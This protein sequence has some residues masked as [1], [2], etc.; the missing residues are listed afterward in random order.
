[1]SSNHLSANFM[2]EETDDEWLKHLLKAP[3]LVRGRVIVTPSFLVCKSR[4]PPNA[5]NPIQTHGLE[6]PGGL[7]HRV[8]NA[9]EPCWPW[10]NL[11][12]VALGASHP[13]TAVDAVQSVHS[14]QGL[15]L[16]AP[17]VHRSP[18]RQVRPAPGC[19]R[20]SHAQAFAG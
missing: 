18:H 16:P 14:L 19:A 5:R 6:E 12:V 11:W 20:R 4:T 8:R 7:G 15:V 10:T 17:V 13:T 3:Q 9:S 2:N 1:M